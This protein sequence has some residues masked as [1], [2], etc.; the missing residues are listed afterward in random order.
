[1]QGIYLPFSKL[2]TY[3]QASTLDMYLKQGVHKLDLLGKI[4]ELGFE[5]FQ[6]MAN[7]VILT[8]L[9]FGD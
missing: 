9:P 7:D 2:H 1:M 6:R 8:G 4:P 5:V 3:I